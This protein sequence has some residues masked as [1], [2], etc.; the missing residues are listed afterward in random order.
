MN[1]TYRNEDRPIHPRDGFYF[2]KMGL[3]DAKGIYRED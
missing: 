3:K 1:S 2:E